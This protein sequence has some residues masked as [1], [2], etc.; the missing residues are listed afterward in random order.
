MRRI[1]IAQIGTG[2]DHAHYT[3][4]SM[5]RLTDDFE[6][7][8]IYEPTAEYLEKSRTWAMFPHFLS[9]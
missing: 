2:H 3:M 6:V 8:G 7:V 1:R 4:E 5:R 9:F